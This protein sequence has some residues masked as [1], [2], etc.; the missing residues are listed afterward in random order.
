MA[1]P[2][3]NKHALGCTKAKNGIGPPFKDVDAQVIFDMA[4]ADCTIEEICAT[5]KIH[6]DTI[7]SRVELAEAL[8]Q[9][10]YHGCG[11]IKS[12]LFKLG[13]HDKHPSILIWLSKVRCGYAEQK[14]TLDQQLIDALSKVMGT[15]KDI[16]DENNSKH[17]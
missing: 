16:V 1:A 5:L 9:G 14:S 7:Y 2:K 3:G 15:S 17:S 8:K 13:V 4:A 6:H 12:A 10:R 11:S